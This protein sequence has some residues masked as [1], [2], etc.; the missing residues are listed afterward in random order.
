LRWEFY[1]GGVAGLLTAFV[2]RAGNLSADLIF[3]EGF[4]AGVRSVVWFVAFAVIDGVWWRGPSRPLVLGAG[5][6]ALLVNL[7]VSGG[8][9][10]PSVAQPLWIMAA[11]ALNTAGVGETSTL[12]SSRGWLWRFLP[13][14]VTAVVC[15]TYIA[16]SF[17]PVM[18]AA[19]LV[20]DARRYYLE[21]RDVRE[22]YW[23]FRLSKTER[24][25]VKQRESIAANNFLDSHII[26]KLEGALKEDPKNAAIWV[27]LSHWQGERWKLFA[28]NKELAIVAI[29]HADEACR[30]DP[31]G[32]Q[33]YQE[34][35]RLHRL[36]AQTALARGNPADAPQQYGMAATALTEVVKRDPNDAGL[37]YQL[38]ECLFLA[39]DAVEGRKVATTALELHERGSDA[40]RRLTERGLTRRQQRQIQRWLSTAPGK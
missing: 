38:A 22:P 15:L 20:T 2:L 29:R 19:N 35:A 21:W 36:F 33:G 31:E 18:T 27:E 34:K 4:L 26:K 13:L 7:L 6:L 8:I 9:A 12:S 1:L 28:Y 11:L 10:L 39:G 40:A 5:L 24:D 32:K 17:S 14:P 37:R 16:L 23:Q 3:V 25:E 30:L